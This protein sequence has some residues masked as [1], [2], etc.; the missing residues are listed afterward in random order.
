MSAMIDWAVGGPDAETRKAG[1]SV[2]ANRLFSGSE[3]LAIA[4]RFALGLLSKQC[5]RGLEKK[6]ARRKRDLDV[7][8]AARAPLKRTL[9]CGRCAECSLE[10]PDQ[11]FHGVQLA[12]LK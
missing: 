4:R 6:S 9:G 5:A 8:Q 2:R 11:R 1:G 3:G 12:N 7:V 10:A